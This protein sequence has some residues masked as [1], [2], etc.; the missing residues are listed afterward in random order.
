[1][2]LDVS[3]IRFI[4]NICHLKTL[5]MLMKFFAFHRAVKHLLFHRYVMLKSFLRNNIRITHLLLN[6][7]IV[8]AFA[9]KKPETTKMVYK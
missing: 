6:F 8:L 7:E 4:M 3:L 5:R 2:D 9:T 1:M